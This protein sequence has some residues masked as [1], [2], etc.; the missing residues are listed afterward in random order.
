MIPFTKELKG[1]TDVEVSPEVKGYCCVKVRG[2]NTVGVL[3]TDDNRFILIHRNEESETYRSP[4]R[5]FT[6]IVKAV[7]R[8]RRSDLQ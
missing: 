1:L 7:E 3:H 4:S 8:R 5:A 2:E 6:S